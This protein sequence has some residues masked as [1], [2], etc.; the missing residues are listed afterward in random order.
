MGKQR[1]SDTSQRKG[2]SRTSS[3]ANIA[4]IVFLS[5]IALVL[6][7]SVALVLRQFFEA[8]E[9]AVATA[10]ERNECQARA[11]SLMVK[12]NELDAAFQSLSREHSEMENLANQQR[13]EINRLKGQ[14]LQLAGNQTIAEVK[15]HVEELETQLAEYQEKAQI[16]SEEN[17][18]LSSENQRVKNTLA[19]TEEQIIELELK[20]Q[21]LTNQIESASGLQIMNIEVITTRS[22]RRGERETSRAGRV[23]KIQTC[24]TILE[25]ILSAPGNRT[26]YIRITGPGGELLSNGQA[27]TFQLIESQVPYT[28]SKVFDYQNQQLVACMNFLPQAD[29]EKGIY[30]VTIYG[31]KREL[32]TQLF[33]LN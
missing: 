12:L 24:F 17:T 32:G 6:A 26:F 23:E 31:E 7:I 11:D 21:S 30:R 8:R 4:P 25:N 22:A 33:E 5:V 2:F 19:L 16:L 27:E 13:I 14:I 15:A 9:L 18:Q 1:L 28:V 20:N 29:L 10:V 3:S